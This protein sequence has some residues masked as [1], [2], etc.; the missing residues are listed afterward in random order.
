LKQPI[1]LDDFPTKHGDFPVRKVSN[2]HYHLVKK[3][4]CF[5][6]M[7]DMFNMF[8]AEHHRNLLELAWLA[9][10]VSPHWRC[11][12]FEAEKNECGIKR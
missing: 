3:S 1:L 6:G 8:G 2:H 7:P 12:A 5:Q 4:I 9:P 11:A 10:F